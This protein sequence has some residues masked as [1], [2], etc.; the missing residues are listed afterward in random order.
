MTCFLLCY[1]LQ[2]T[3]GKEIELQKWEL[4]KRSEFYRFP[5]ATVLTRKV[6]ACEIDI[7]ESGTLIALRAR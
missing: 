4:A 7:P 2:L 5:H 1:R 3:K 6:I